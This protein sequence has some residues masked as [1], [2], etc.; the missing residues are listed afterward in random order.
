MVDYA[1]S[2]GLRGGPTAPGDVVRSAAMRLGHDTDTTAAVASGIAGVIHG[3]RASERAEAERCADDR[4]PL[5]RKLMTPR[6]TVMETQAAL[7]P[8]AGRN[9]RSTPAKSAR[10]VARVDMLHPFGPRPPLNHHDT[11]DDMSK[12]FT[13]ARFKAGF[14]GCR[15]VWL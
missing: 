14:S 9:P 12:W 15:G 1:F 11:D 3:V 5:L 6:G 13:T 10:P 2:P 7:P 8:G 4:G